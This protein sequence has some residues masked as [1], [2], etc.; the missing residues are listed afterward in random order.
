MSGIV[1]S[2]FNIKGSGLVGS[3]GTDGQVFTSS[4]AGAGAVYEDA[5]G[6]AWGFV[7]T[8]TASSSSSLD[9]TNMAD[10]YDYLYVL[11]NLLPATDGSTMK[12]LLGVSGPTY[13]TAS[14]KGCSGTGGA[15]D[16]AITAYATIGPDPG[17]STLGNVTDEGMRRGQIEFSNPANAGTKTVWTAFSHNHDQNNPKNTRGGGVYTTAEAH[18]AL[19]FIMISG[20]L[21]SGIIQQYRRI[22]S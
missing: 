6:G 14:Y 22:R 4:G 5:A 2:R 7:S 1:G 9:F 17:A 21:A 11:E 19:R 20:N 3:L 16:I 8:L 18:P 12:A 13:R 15:D 10:G